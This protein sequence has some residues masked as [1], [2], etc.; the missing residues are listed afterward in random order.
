MFFKAAISVGP[1]PPIL[2]RTDQV[3]A[4]AVLGRTTLGTALGATVSA[5]QCHSA[6]TGSSSP[7]RGGSE[8]PYGAQAF[9]TLDTTSMQVSAQAPPH[10]L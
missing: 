10:V 4:D 2:Y 5:W 6:D 7:V 1:V 8:Q 9:T 3:W